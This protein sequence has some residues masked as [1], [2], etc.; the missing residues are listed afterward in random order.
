M[1]YAVISDIH[2]NVFALKKTLELLSQENVSKIICLGDAI[3]IGTRS[4]ECVQLLK[5]Y[6]DKLIYVRGNHEDRCIFGV[7]DYI[8]NGQHKMTE[9]DLRQESWIK[10]HLSKESIDFISKLPQETSITLEGIKIAVTHYP[11][12]ENMEYRE[13]NL[14]PSIPE[15][16]EYFKKYDADIYLYGHTHTPKANLSQ[17]GKWYINPGTLGTTDFGDYGTYGIITIDG[18][19]I[20]YVQKAFYYDLKAA[21]DDFEIMNPPRKDHMRDKFFGYKR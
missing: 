7:P 16:I 19:N 15:L 2:G 12:D 21:L 9:E 1:K 20:S 17:E 18:Q 6:E 4:E 11:S 10:E 3:G 14:F 13:F 5:Q 8:H